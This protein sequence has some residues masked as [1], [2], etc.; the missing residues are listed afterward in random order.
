MYT[1]VQALH[2][3]QAF[4]RN[5]IFNVEKIITSTTLQTGHTTE[6]D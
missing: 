4:K 1:A 3:M 6:Q 2:V 5:L